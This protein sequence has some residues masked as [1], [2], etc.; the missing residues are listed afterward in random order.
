MTA[1][2]PKMTSTSSEDLRIGVGLRLTDHA[3]DFAVTVSRNAN[4]RATGDSVGDS[5][6]QRV[7]W[8]TIYLVL[9]IVDRLAFV[10]NRDWRNATMAVLEPAALGYAISRISAM[11]LASPGFAEALAEREQ[12]IA[13]RHAWYGKMHSSVPL[14]EGDPEW[15]YARLAAAVFGHTEEDSLLVND[16]A[17]GIGLRLGDL[18]LKAVVDD[19][20]RRY[21]LA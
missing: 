8:E 16:I 14:E 10:K 21:P 18:K 9:H 2:V 1:V 6:I 19:L 4:L 5:A 3:I 17:M 20:F 12:E 15:E 7:M 13:Q 11:D